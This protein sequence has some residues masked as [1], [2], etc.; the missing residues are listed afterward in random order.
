[1][2]LC[3]RFDFAKASSVT[4]T[5]NWTSGRL[6]KQQRSAGCVADQNGHRPAY[7]RF[8]K[9]RFSVGSRVVSS[10]D[11]PSPAHS[12]IT[13]SLGGTIFAV[14]AGDLRGVGYTLVNGSS[15]L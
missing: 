7:T 15:P 3:Y 13:P 5:Q 2:E 8:G 1:M 14:K 4:F 9:S 11:F 6:R 12:I 10:A